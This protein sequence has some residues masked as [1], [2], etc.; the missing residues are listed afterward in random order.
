MGLFI[1]GIVS[2]LWLSRIYCGWVCPINTAMNLIVWIKKKIQLRTSKT[3]SFIANPLVKYIVLAT[4]IAAFFLSTK[5]GLKLPV[6]PVVF[7]LGI[8]TTIFFAPE[9]WHRNLCP[10][11]TILSL[12]AR[13]A[14]YSVQVSPDKCVNC[15][16]CYQVCPAKS[17]KRLSESHQIIKNECL[18]CIEC[19]RKCPK[20]A[21]TYQ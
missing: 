5:L 9:V 2:A 13:M 21:I 11:G 8:V 4:F 3:P 18:V 6:L 19:V 15:G 7:V 10:F 17:V 20:D 1:I 14:G 16:I 12:P